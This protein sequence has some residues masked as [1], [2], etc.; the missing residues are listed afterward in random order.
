MPKKLTPE[1][2]EI[3][4]DEEREILRAY[5]SPEQPTMKVL[6]RRC[7]YSI[8]TIHRKIKDA[9]HRRE[10]YRKSRGL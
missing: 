1:E 9:S 7:G 8:A 6:A 10:A 5:E 2:R 4:E 3:K